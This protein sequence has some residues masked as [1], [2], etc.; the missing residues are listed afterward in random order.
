MNFYFFHRPE[1]RKYTY[2]SP[3]HIPEDEKLVNSHLYDSVQFGEKLHRSWENRRRAKNNP[4]KNI[5]TIIW[6][7]FLVFVLGWAGWKLFY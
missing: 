5:R 6:I 3:F 2:K 4:T 7:A 1:A